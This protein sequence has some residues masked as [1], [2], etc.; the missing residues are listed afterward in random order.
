M[1]RCSGLPGGPK[2]NGLIFI[3]SAAGSPRH[4]HRAHRGTYTRDTW[5]HGAWSVDPWNKAARRTP[6]RGYSVHIDR[7]DGTPARCGAG[8][9]WKS[10]FEIMSQCPTATRTPSSQQHGGRRGTRTT[11]VPVGAHTG[12]RFHKSLKLFPTRTVHIKYADCALVQFTPPFTASQARK[13]ICNFCMC[14]AR[15]SKAAARQKR[16]STLKSPPKNPSHSAHSSTAPK[17]TPAP[18]RASSAGIWHAR[19]TVPQ[20]HLKH[21]QRHH[22]RTSESTQSSIAMHVRAGAHGNGQ[23]H[24]AGDT[25][26]LRVPRRLWRGPR[27]G[28]GPGE[29]P[30]PSTRALH[31]AACAVRWPRRWRRWRWRRRR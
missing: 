18:G 7:G 31:A 21:A 10:R 15:M 13:M 17:A 12:G 9:R 5:I 19:Q 14:R 20:R 4:R 25:P 16:P 27:R 26:L 2:S 23:G 22:T 11:Q 1:F 28:R 24:R 3:V 6:G 8:A 30:S 29:G